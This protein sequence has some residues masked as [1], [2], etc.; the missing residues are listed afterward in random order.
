MDKSQYER[1][2]NVDRR[3]WWFQLRRDIAAALLRLFLANDK[4]IRIIDIGTGTGG[5]LPVLSQ[6]GSVTAAEPDPDAL[7]FTRHEYS[8][9]PSCQ[10]IQSDWQGLNMPELEF[11]LLTAFDVLEHCEDDFQALTRWRKMVKDGGRMLITVP[12]FN[13]LWGANDDLSHHYRRYSKTTLREVILR[14]SLVV[15]KISYINSMMFLPVW[16]SRNLKEPIEKRLGQ[17]KAA[18]WDFDLPYAP[19]NA[20]F[21]ML[22]SCEKFVLPF[23]DLPIGTSLIALVRVLN[24]AAASSTIHGQ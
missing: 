18:P 4:S 12:A 6:F 10:F 16:L 11:D 23:M 3:H 7:E 8:Y 19:I 15:E 1:F 9:L 22:F 13:S 21:R 20:M 17:K 5:M 14:S 2:A 24:S